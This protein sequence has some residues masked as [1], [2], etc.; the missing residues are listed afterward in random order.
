MPSIDGR[1][2]HDWR[3]SRGWD[4]PKMAR[5]LRRAACEAQ[6]SVAAH[7]GLIRMIRDWERGK[8]TLTERYE[9]LYAAALGVEPACLA[10]GP[11]RSGARRDLAQ[12][13]V[14]PLNLRMAHVMLP[15]SAGAE[16]E[17][18]D[19]REFGLAM[20][21]LL[22]GTLVTPT[23]VP[24]AVTTEHLR[25]L[26]ATATSIWTRDRL[27]GGSAQLR[28]AVT[29]YTTARAMLDYSSYTSTIG[30]ELQLVTSELAVCA[31]FA[32]HDADHQPLA[33][34]LLTEATLLAAGD[35]LLS[36]R[37]YGLL[38]LQSNALAVADHGRAREALRFLDMADAAARHEPSPRVHALIWMR[39]ANACGILDDDANVR[40]SIA[41]ARRELDRG[42][43]PADP[44]WAGFVDSTE[45][46]AHEA[47]A[48][49][50]QGKPK[51]A[52]GLFRD[53]LADADLPPRN[54][55]LYTAQLAA[56]L[57]AA[58]DQNEAID[59]GLQVLD[60]L[61]GTV[62]SARVLHEL[63]PVR[64]ATDSSGEFAARYDTA[65]AS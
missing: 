52:A 49:L 55:A 65:L 53:V 47:I 37:A 50:G 22:A 24:A 23:G 11:A 1:K 56:C 61:E 27:I 39:R 3:R 54:R 6:E 43:H 9:L 32:A 26:R 31:G 16:E 36:A 12:L 20:V 25:D 17:D 44:R 30:A 33:R 5:Q 58:G 57:H 45:V 19:R 60:A 35:T 15:E 59:A 51:A 2:L 21:G 63:R 64:Q 28:E 48:R 10:N 62:R 42:D 14:L 7:D 18:V 38:A 8:H 4:V 13:P 29:R 46:T 40:R 34:T 41:N